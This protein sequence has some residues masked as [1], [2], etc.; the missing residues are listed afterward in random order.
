MRVLIWAYSLIATLSFALKIG[1]TFDCFNLLGKI[2]V[3]NI[4]LISSVKGFANRFFA[5]LRYP[6]KK[7]RVREVWCLL[8]LRCILDT[9]VVLSSVVVDITLGLSG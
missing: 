4:W 9:S 3:F 7:H 8:L 2:P 6:V 5:A 1:V